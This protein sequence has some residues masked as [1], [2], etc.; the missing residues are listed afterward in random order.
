MLQDMSL[1]SVRCFLESRLLMA[2]EDSRLISFR[3]NLSVE[4][5]RV[6]YDFLSDLD[7]P[8]YKPF[9]KS[10]SKLIKDVL[11]TFVT[12]GRKGL[13]GLEDNNSKKNSSENVEE[14]T[15][16][17]RDS[18]IDGLEEKIAHLIST[19]VKTA[20]KDA[21]EGK[22]ISESDKFQSHNGSKEKMDYSSDGNVKEAE[23]LP[24]TS[25]DMPDDVFDYLS[26]L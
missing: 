9:I 3:V 13:L 16:V 14:T 24:N 22:I 11:Y 18:V 25:N 8:D 26:N 6:I 1:L 5:D 12:K 10:K 2:N 4:Q 7:D 21:L 17:I 23:L 20:I 19:N 15:K